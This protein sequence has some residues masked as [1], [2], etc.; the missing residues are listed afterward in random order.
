MKTTDMFLSADERKIGNKNIPIILSIQ[1]TPQGQVLSPHVVSLRSSTGARKL[2]ASHASQK[3][4]QRA[5]NREMQGVDMRIKEDK[6]DDEILSSIAE[7]FRGKNA[8]VDFAEDKIKNKK[9]ASCNNKPLIPSQK[10][11]FQKMKS[12]NDGESGFLKSWFGGV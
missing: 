6:N 12:V 2:P 4:S 11:Q 1:K 10:E 8:R 5:N 7:L 3:L 9:S